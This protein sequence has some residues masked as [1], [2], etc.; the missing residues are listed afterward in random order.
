MGHAT[1]VTSKGG[2]MKGEVFHEG[3]LSK[4]GY[5]CLGLINRDSSMIIVTKCIEHTCSSSYCIFRVGLNIQ[6]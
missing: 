2:L 6:L 3:G 5:H 1:F 4:G